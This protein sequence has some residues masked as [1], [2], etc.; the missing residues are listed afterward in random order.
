[1]DPAQALTAADDAAGTGKLDQPATKGDDPCGDRR[2]RVCA[3]PGEGPAAVTAPS[4]PLHRQNS[5]AV[6]HR[7]RRSARAREHCH[8]P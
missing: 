1:M 4:R 2:R 5:P 6:G 3:D 8:G 7:S